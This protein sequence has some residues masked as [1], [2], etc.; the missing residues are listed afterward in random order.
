MNKEL[1]IVEGLKHASEFRGRMIERKR[2]AKFLRD[3]ADTWQKTLIFNFRTELH[4]L[5]ETIEKGTN[6]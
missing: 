2:V 3:Y 5:A 1:Q 4:K 6:E